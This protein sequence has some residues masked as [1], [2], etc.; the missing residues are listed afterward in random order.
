MQAQE[1]K[2]RKK[3]KECNCWDRIR[4]D[5]FWKDIQIFNLNEYV[6][7]IKLME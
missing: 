7:R 5:N 3:V 2:F 1:M 6:D 4:S